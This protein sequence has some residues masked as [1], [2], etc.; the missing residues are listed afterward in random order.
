MWWMLILLTP[1]AY[2]QDDLSAIQKLD[3]E[4]PEI[5]DYRESKEELEFS[6][7]N[8]KYLPP[9]RPVSMER[10]VES[11]TQMVS[12]SGGSPLRNLATNKDHMTTKQMYLKV[13]NRE[14]E[15]GYKY[16]Q[17]KDGT[18][19]WRVNNRYVEPIKQELELYE[20]PLKYTP[21][22]KNIVRSEFDK[23]LT[24]PP[25]VSFYAGMV[26]GAFMADL[27][28]D[29]KA[30]NGTSTQYGV[31]FFTEWK[32]PI[33]VGG[34]LHYEYSTYDLSNGN[35]INYSSLSLGPQL[36]SRD[37]EVFSWPIRLQ[38]Q[39]RVSP[40]ARAAADTNDGAKNYKFNSADVMAGVE[41]PIKNGLGEFVLGLYVQAQWL[42]L[43]DQPD[44]VSVKAS[45]KTN[46]SF[47]L[48]ISQVFQ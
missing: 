36:K 47:G 14:D 34:V 27:F 16:I 28:N 13:F 26:N 45:N 6:R 44:T 23:K 33:K 20:P 24:L 1:L 30:S 48:S 17:G 21:A 35:K 15:H 39:F 41:H 10:I 2:A 11:G 9:T 46:N 22:P 19:L 3:R 31:H 5:D 18:V 43:K 12:I 4:L 42:N 25:E 29:S 7:Q 38:T 40:L 37:F 8:R 32:L